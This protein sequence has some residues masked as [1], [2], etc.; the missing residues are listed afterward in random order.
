LDIDLPR[1]DELYKPGDVLDVNDSIDIEVPKAPKTPSPKTQ[2]PEDEGSEDIQTSDGAPEN[3]D[4]IIDAEVAPW[5]TATIMDAEVAPWDTETIVD[6]EVAPWDTETSEPTETFSVDNIKPPVNIDPMKVAEDVDWGDFDITAWREKSMTARAF[7]YYDKI[8]DPQWAGPATVESVTEAINQANIEGQRIAQEYQGTSVYDAAMA[9]QVQLVTD[10]VAQRDALRFRGKQE[11]AADDLSLSD[12]WEYVITNKEKVAFDML[13]GIV[14]EPDLIIASGAVGFAAGTTVPVIGNATVGTLGLITGTG[15]RAAQV[16]KGIKMAMVPMAQLGGAY[17]GGRLEGAFSRA[18]DK[19]AQD[20]EFDFAKGWEQAHIDGLFGMTVVAGIGVAVKGSKKV[21]N[22][23]KKS[24]EFSEYIETTDE[25]NF[26]IVKSKFEN[27]RDTNN[28]EAKVE[29]A[30]EVEEG[31][32]YVDPKGNVKVFRPEVK[33]NPELDLERVIE[34]T[35]K[36]RS[37]LPKEKVDKL[38]KAYIKTSEEVSQLEVKYKAITD[39]IKDTPEHL[40]D[41]DIFK[42]LNKTQ[43]E[44]KEKT[45][46]LNGMEKRLQR[47]DEAVD[48]FNELY[49][50]TQFKELD[51]P[52]HM[53]T[54]NANGD[55]VM[56]TKY[57]PEIHSNGKIRIDGINPDDIIY[58]ARG[59]GKPNAFTKVITGLLGRAMAPVDDIFED[60]ATLRLLKAKL[61][62]DPSRPNTPVWT[63]TEDIRLKQGQVAA[64]YKEILESI[65]NK[66]L[67]NNTGG[68]EDLIKQLRNPEHS[69]DPLIIKAATDIKQLLKDNYEY[70][71]GSGIKMAALDDYLPRVM[72]KEVLR[73]PEG[74]KAYTDLLLIKQDRGPK[75]AEETIKDI[76]LDRQERDGVLTEAG[77]SLN[78]T[79][80]GERTLN[81]ITDT[82]LDSVGLL[83]PD[84]LNDINVSLMSGIKRAEMAKVYGD[85]GSTL[86]KLMEQINDELAERG[87]TLTEP[88]RQNFLDVYNSINGTHGKIE[89]QSIH[90]LQDSALTLSNLSSLGLAGITSTVEPLINIARMN[91]TGVVKSTAKVAGVYLKAPVVAIKELTKLGAIKLLPAD[92]FLSKALKGL[93]EDVAANEARTIGL[94][95]DIALEETLDAISG[96]SMNSNL[97]KDVNK[98]FFLANGLHWV[99]K[100]SRVTAMEIGKAD[101]MDNLKNLAKEPNS[102]VRRDWLMEVNLNPK[103]ALEWAKAGADTSSPYYQEILRASA[104]M[105]DEV[106]A[107]PN[108]T[109]RSTGFSNH[110]YKLIT[111]FKSFMVTFTNVILKRQWANIAKAKEQGGSVYALNRMMKASVSASIL[112]G[113]YYAMGMSKE[114]MK[115]GFELPDRSEDDERTAILRAGISMTGSASILES[116][117]YALDNND[118][119]GALATTVAP[120]TKIVKAAADIVTGDVGRGVVSLTPGIANLSSDTKRD[121]AKGIDKEIKEVLR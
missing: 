31:V 68:P 111:Q 55:T 43:V 97:L 86:K 119:L 98:K 18:L 82:E 15:L 32:A 78:K 36:T 74:A 64:Q 47:H 114:F 90:N 93:P 13:Q 33:E 8:T 5:D 91:S 105:A 6:A 53:A 117:A 63:M 71:K 83:G 113:G 44:L 110:K 10:L 20:G 39:L 37:K 75:E 118:K 116:L 109:N 100:H 76:L 35:P 52:Q 38:N 50:Y 12:M 120:S 24:E 19:A 58:T 1:G 34:L 27:E 40:K 104:R 79:P 22:S 42:R 29:R 77:G 70:M 45:T 101:I 41:Q 69:Q 99:T 21:L 96:G 48:A 73:T 17:A 84:L 57:D 80:Y 59:M 56:F 51:T 89:S 26:D 7:K 81:H 2:S 94:T 112:F 108:A 14:A 23:R 30:L 85:G 87:K 115:N 65:N 72:N 54:T 121:V 16:A 102:R 88:Q 4:T 106:V 103:D 9:D 66:V 92:N 67:T 60:S 107:N 49:G 62:V 25:T 95:M 11:E 61:D 3:T 28:I 46:Q